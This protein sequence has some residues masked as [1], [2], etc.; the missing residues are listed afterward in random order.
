MKKIIVIIL[1]LGSGLSAAYSQQDST[2]L[3]RALHKF[4]QSVDSGNVAQ[5]IPFYADGFKNIRVVDEG[6][7]ITMDRQQMIN[8]W[9]MQSNKKNVFDQQKIVVEKTTIN[10][11]EVL[12]DMA[13]ILLTRYKDLGSGIEPMFYTLVWKKLDNKWLLFREFVHQRT[14]PKFS[15]H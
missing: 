12:G 11:K 8:F 6:P 7:L 14:M 3:D 10:F 9:K 13:Y 1:S 5:V 15:P 2:L 4:M